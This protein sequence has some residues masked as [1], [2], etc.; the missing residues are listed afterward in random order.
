MG[1]G[2]AGPNLYDSGRDYESLS[3]RL[4]SGHADAGE[5]KVMPIFPAARGTPG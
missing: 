4:F 2:R 1:R 5:V 3:W